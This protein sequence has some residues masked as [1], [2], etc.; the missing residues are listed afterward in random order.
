MTTLNRA[1]DSFIQQELFAK[2]HPAIVTPT[3]HYA[4]HNISEDGILEGEQWGETHN[5]MITTID[6]NGSV[7]KL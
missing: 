3:P 1:V 6:S 4:L 7:F 2:P 5:T